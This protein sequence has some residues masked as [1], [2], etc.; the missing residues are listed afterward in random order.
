MASNDIAPA[1]KGTQLTKVHSFLIA[2]QW[3]Q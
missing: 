1:M 2:L 3:L